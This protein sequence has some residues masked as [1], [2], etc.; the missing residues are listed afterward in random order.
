MSVGEPTR[1]PGGRTA[2]TTRRVNDAAVELLLEAGIGGCTFGAVA[3]RAGVERSTLYRRYE[4]RWMMIMDATIASVADIT[5][6]S[7]GSFA[8]DLTTI[9]T[10]GAETLSGPFGQVVLALAAALRG[11]AREFHIHRFWEGRMQQ[12]AP[13]FDAAIARGE[14]RKD[15]NRTELFAFAAGPLYF[16]NLFT[17]Q[18]VDDVWI[19]RI[20]EGVCDRYCINRNGAADSGRG[21][22][23]AGRARHRS[24]P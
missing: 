9:L 14:L 13:M 8:T 17:A 23:E 6:D 10:R 18:T 12:I 11:T 7:T 20:V 24:S 2:E 5:S 21:S 3:K 15:V 22:K 16:R 19:G 4:D 1:R